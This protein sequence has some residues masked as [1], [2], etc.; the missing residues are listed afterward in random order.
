[1]CAYLYS[2]YAYVLRF[3]K[4]AFFY[5]TLQH[6]NPQQ[7]YE[8][9]FTYIGICIIITTVLLLSSS[10]LSLRYSAQC[11]ALF[12]NQLV[13]HSFADSDSAEVFVKAT[14]IVTDVRTYLLIFM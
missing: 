13:P 4:C 8:Y 2:I 11:T 1:M 6:L 12:L 7:I 5:I 9:N 10:V 14:L 3:R